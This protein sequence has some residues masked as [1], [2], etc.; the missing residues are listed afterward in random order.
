MY[1]PIAASASVLSV[2]LI[3]ESLWR[4]KKVKDETARKFVH[5]TVGA[6]VAFWPFFMSWPMIQVM[7]VAFLVVVIL[8]RKFQFFRAIHS[9]ARKTNGELWFAVVIGLLATFMQSEWIFWAA[10]MHLALADGFAAII[11]TAL[12]KKT[13]YSV[14]GQT[15][16]LVGTLMFWVISVTVIVVLTIL[17]PIEFMIQPYLLIVMLPLAVTLL[18]NAAPNGADNVA[19]PLFVAFALNT[20]S[21]AT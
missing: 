18:E 20:L 17:S 9:V 11:G 12:G 5:M 14:F 16:S 2:L 3:S 7:S 6:F 4:S 10:M 13:R 21:L 15:K 1:W 8:S 19:V